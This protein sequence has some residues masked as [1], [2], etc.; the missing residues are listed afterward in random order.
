M[1]TE[2]RTCKVLYMKDGTP[3]ECGGEI[4]KEKVKEPFGNH[5]VIG[6]PI[7]VIFTYEYCASCNVMYHG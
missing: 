1:A 4:K 2:P 5:S 7:P 6:S 3:A